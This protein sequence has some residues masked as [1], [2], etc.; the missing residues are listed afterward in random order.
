[1]SIRTHIVCIKDIVEVRPDIYYVFMLKRSSVGHALIAAFTDIAE[2]L[3]ISRRRIYAKTAIPYE[4]YFEHRV[5]REKR[6]AREQLRNLKRTGYLRDVKIGNRLGVA[7][8]QK[9]ARYSIVHCLML[10]NTPL[11]VGL[12]C[13]VSFDIP[14]HQ[15][16]VRVDLRILLKRLGFRKEHQ[17][18]WSSE[19]D[20]VGFFREFIAA[21][22]A[23]DWVKAFL[24]DPI[25]H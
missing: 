21:S 1:M 24:G 14:E 17:S 23:D 20:Y 9:G 12:R 15:R 11:P 2:D 22:K 19:Y 16:H 6:R 3:T 25:T 13:Y 18:L 10:Q 5:W 8:T 7:L 4:T